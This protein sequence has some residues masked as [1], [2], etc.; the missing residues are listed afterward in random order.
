MI[1][2]QFDSLLL[3][4][5]LFICSVIQHKFIEHRVS[6]WHCFGN[7]GYLGKQDHKVPALIR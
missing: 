1:Y 5:P 7:W 4:I 2:T 3:S 6:T